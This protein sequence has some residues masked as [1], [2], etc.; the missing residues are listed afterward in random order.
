METEESEEDIFEL[1]VDLV[2]EAIESG[3]L[4]SVRTLFQNPNIEDIINE[5]N[6]NE[7]Y[8]LGLAAK[9][10]HLEIVK[11][12]ISRG[13]DHQTVLHEAAK[14]TSIE[15]INYLVKPINEGGV[16]IDVNIA[17]N[18][19]HKMTDTPLH[20][21][22]ISGSEIAARHL[23]SLGAKVDAKEE[24]LSTPLLLACQGRNC[25]AVAKLL[26]EHGAD[27]NTKNEFGDTP[28]HGVA[29]VGGFVL[30]LLLENGAD[31]HT[32][33]VHGLTPFDVA[34]K[35]GQKETALALF[36][37]G[38][39]MEL[40]LAHQYGILEWQRACFSE[41]PPP[42]YSHSACAAGSKIFM[43]GGYGLYDQFN[44]KI[45]NIHSEGKYLGDFYVLDTSKVN[46]D[47]IVDI[48]LQTSSNLQFQLDPKRSSPLAHF[49]EDFMRADFLGSE[50]QQ[51]CSVVA[52]HPFQKNK[53][54]S[55]GYFEVSIIN[56]GTDDTLCVGLCD[57]KY[58]MTK[59]PGWKFD[60]WG[61][62]G[63][64]G[65]I[66]HNFPDRGSL[67]G[68]T[69]TT[70]DVIGCG[71]NFNT[72]QIFFSKNGIFLGVASND[73]NV[74][75]PLFPIIGLMEGADVRINFGQG[76]QPFKF[77]L[78]CH[79]FSW[80][81]IKV[82][83]FFSRLIRNERPHLI[84]LNENEILFL[85]ESVFIFDIA[86]NEFNI[87]K[88]TLKL[89]ERWE[90]TFQKIENEMHDDRVFIFNK[91]NNDFF[92]LHLTDL[93]MCS[94][95]PTINTP[96]F[97]SNMGKTELYS[98]SVGHLFYF[99]SS[100][101]ENE[102][103]TFNTQTSEWS[104]C[105]PKGKKPHG[106]TRCSCTTSGDH[107]V[108]FGGWDTTSESQNDVYIL[109]T[110]QMAWYK[111]NLQGLPVPQPRMDHCSVAID[112]KIYAIGGWSGHTFLPDCDIL[113]CDSDKIKKIELFYYAF[114]NKIFS[115]FLYKE[116]LNIG[117]IGTERKDIISFLDSVQK[118]CP[119]IYPHIVDRIILNRIILPS[120]CFDEIKF[121][122]NN[123]SFIDLTIIVREKEFKV[124]KCILVCR[125][126]YF[127]VL[128]SSGLSE[129]RS[130]RIVLDGSEGDETDAI[131][132]QYVLEYI[133]YDCIEISEEINE[134]VV[135]ILIAS[136]KYEV[137][138]CQE[139]MEELI[140]H[141]LSLENVLSLALVADQHKALKLKK[142]CHQFITHPN[143][144]DAIFQSEE[145]VTCKKE[146]D[147]I[148]GEDFYEFRKKEIEASTLENK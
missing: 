139:I 82:P 9:L 115:E 41:L 127:R 116:E 143:N 44:S 68:P 103:H 42:R 22:A 21:A 7:E 36:E 84:T 26:I 109:D 133:Y 24:T 94:I 51:R 57:E 12:L 16:G 71:I 14:G 5:E 53:I 75:F 56:S 130:D 88:V 55:V 3:D 100:G 118:L 128:L 62:H 1:D 49:S 54:S 85:C 135:P 28:L 148:Y 95:E 102:V 11:Y 79:M 10:G 83:K 27:V 52:N 126:K 134:L 60:S 65:K 13:V 48:H 105:S 33:N 113:E 144:L 90:Y 50:L 37:A 125:S 108:I 76:S 93:S 2:L 46:I 30:K 4:E 58:K 132:F 141:N 72:G 114:D 136:S 131:V 121:G 124:H 92:I 110:K 59:M 119:S 89:P 47:F 63:D 38:S 123:P 20:D 45:D 81:K 80:K 117:R 78:E 70:G 98:A 6:E 66:Y 40:S 96:S 15:M 64:D 67:W 87:N 111:P 43:C 104:F 31:I 69:F 91:L 138:G 97:F 23:I 34:V 129:S 147:S 99:W 29:E 35:V 61:Y 86:K 32:K 106:N 77:D 25:V 73:A 74:N 145:Y 19:P 140:S 39:N 112:N 18:K 120:I 146:I 8:P 137:T 101:G 122:W 17:A 142:S 107:I